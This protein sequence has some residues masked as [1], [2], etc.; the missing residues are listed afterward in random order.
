MAL[1]LQQES[2]LRHHCPN[3][4]DLALPGGSVSGPQFR[5]RRI[6]ISAWKRQGRAKSCSLRAST[7]S[8]VV[9]L[10]AHVPS[11]GCGDLFK[12]FSAQPLD[13]ST[14]RTWDMSGT[15]TH[16]LKGHVKTTTTLL[17]LSSPS[18]Q[19]TLDPF[20]QRTPSRVTLQRAFKGALQ[21]HPSSFPFFF[22]NPF[23]TQLL[24]HARTHSPFHPPT[25][26]FKAHLKKPPVVFSG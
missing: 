10:G 9:G 15:D 19:D 8:D 6:G 1:S 24:T 26:P 13:P 21:G 18:L 2:Q 11:V 7:R 25:H 14:V 23:Y 4:D 12:G 3:D 16:R 17:S 22:F 20:L 5:H